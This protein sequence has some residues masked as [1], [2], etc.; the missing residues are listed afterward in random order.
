MNKL[1]LVFLLVFA[2]VMIKAQTISLDKVARYELPYQDNKALLAAAETRSKQGKAPQFAVSLP[3]DINP[4]SHGTWES[5]GDGRKQWRLRIFSAGAKSLNLGFTDYYMPRGG[6]MRLYSPD[7]Q[8]VQGPF[9]PADNESHGQLWTP[10]V[11]GEELIIELTIPEKA[12][13]QVL[14]QLGF[15]NHDFL[16]FGQIVSGS[17]NLDA[18][19]GFVDGFGIVDDY[20]DIIRSVGVYG[21]NGNTFCTGFLI[22]NTANDCRPFFMTADH[23]GLNSGNAPS[24]VVYWNFE[25]STCR[26]PNSAASGANGD[27]QLT[28]FNSGSVYRAGWDGSDFALVELDDDVPTEY[29]PFF[30]GFD[31]TSGATG[32][33]VICVHHPNTEEKRISFEFD[34]TAIASIG[35]NPNPNGNYVVVNDWDIGTTEGGSSG[36]PLFDKQKRVIGQLFGGQAACGNNAYDVYGWIHRSWTGGGTSS[37]RLQ[38]WLDPTNTGLLVMDGRECG[39]NII[40]NPRILDLCSPLNANYNLQASEGFLDSVQLSIT[41]LPAGVAVNLSPNPIAPGDFSTLTLSNLTPLL[42]GSF[43]FTLTGTDGIDTTIKTLSLVISQ[44]I[45]ISSPLSPANGAIE[46]TSSPLL[47]WIALPLT[48]YVVELATDSNFVNMVGIGGVQAGQWSPGNLMEETDYYWRVK[49]TNVCGAGNYSPTQRFRTGAL[50]CGGTASSDV[51]KVIPS[52]G[53]NTITSTIVVTEN[54]FIEDLNLRNLNIDHTWVG[55]LVITLTSPQN[56]EVILLD[57]ISCVSEDIRADFDDQSPLTYADLINDCPFANPAINGAYQPLQSLSNFNGDQMQ[58]IWT[59]TVIDNELGDGGTINGWELEFCSTVESALLPIPK[60]A[61]ICLGQ[62]L[63]FDILIGDS[64]NANPGVVLTITDLPAGVSFNINTVPTQP[65]T[66]VGASLSPFNTTGQYEVQVNAIDGVSQRSAKL[67]I[68][69][70]DRAEANLLF[71][72]DSVSQ[73]SL[74][75]ILH[76]ESDFPADSFK[77]ELALDPSFNNIVQTHY[78]IADSVELDPLDHAVYYHWRVQAYNDC[79]DKLSSPQVFATAWATSIAQELGLSANIF[80]NPAREKLS[81]ELASPLMHTLNWELIS[82]T[83]QSLDQGTLP[84]GVLGADISLRSYPSGL[85][86]L[87]LS[88]QEYRFTERFFIQK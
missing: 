88:H 21:L 86:F 68:N 47:E 40:T 2:C 78:S 7:M 62:G 11:E 87:R 26:Q 48:Q 61:E 58:G 15:I 63:D 74:T 73:V 18:V 82:F 32:D 81:L 59:L 57:Q 27:G 56:K 80:P 85:Y 5:L 35:G 10:I 12:Q 6:S 72:V 38:D 8:M 67:T 29:L 66:I 22:N 54:G 28:Q 17:C 31:A 14:L 77:V 76:W 23:C 51:P 69:V 60:E 9:S 71:P 16:G 30:A 1:S 65:N 52:S 34:L 64:F 50:F 53:F 37:T 83:G 25:N 46:V 39:P 20:R 45:P 44:G 84:A 4:N 79:G 24:I 70:I 75:P 55:D 13:N 36:S 3:V 19:C 43:D 49:G 42:A 41:G 33:S